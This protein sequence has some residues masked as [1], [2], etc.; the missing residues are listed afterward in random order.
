MVDAGARWRGPT[1]TK[2]PQMV[3]TDAEAGVPPPLGE[4]F[5]RSGR[6]RGPADRSGG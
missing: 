1:F 4:Y 5:A 2:E 3:T 6:V